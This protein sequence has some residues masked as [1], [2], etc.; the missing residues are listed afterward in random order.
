MNRQE[1]ALLIP[2]LALSIPV[3]AIIFTSLV[4]MTKLKADAQRAALPNPEVEAR[5]AALE[6]EVASL[7]HELVETQERLDFTERLLTQRSQ[8]KSESN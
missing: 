7:R 1:L 5:V 4:K 3:V 2:L 8:V 6:E